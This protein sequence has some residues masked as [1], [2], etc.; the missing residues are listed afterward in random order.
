MNARSRTASAQASTIVRKPAAAKRGVRKS[1]EDFSPADFLAH[2][3]LGKMMVQHPKGACIFSQG[4]AADA[5]FFLQAGGVKISVVSK[6]GKEAVIALLGPGEFAGEECIASGHPVRLTTA[7]ALSQCSLLK[8]SRKEMARVLGQ[9]HAMS[10]IFV[11]FLLER[12]AHIQANLIDQLFN[13]SEK[14]LARVLLLLAHFGKE[15]KPE[16]V[17]PRLSQETLAEMVGTTRSR[18]SLFMNRFRK[19]GFIEYGVTSGVNMQVH[20]SLLNVI[21]H[22]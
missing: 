21:L 19:M 8:I 6:R 7:T 10:D 22:D 9:E 17:V 5:V 1:E 14:R 2:A 18:V 11:S 4:D 3:G 16:T 20:N 13:S 15:G 12:N